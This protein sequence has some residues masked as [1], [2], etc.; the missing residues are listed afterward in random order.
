MTDNQTPVATFKAKAKHLHNILEK[1]HPGIKLAEC[2]EALSKINGYRDWNTASALMQRPQGITDAQ[3]RLL[4][5]STKTIVPM[6][7]EITAPYPGLARYS[8]QNCAK[9]Y[10]DSRQRQVYEQ[11][12]IHSEEGQEDITFTFA[13]QIVLTEDSITVQDGVTELY[14]PPNALTTATKIV[15]AQLM[16][17][18]LEPEI[19][20]IWSEP[21]GYI[22]RIRHHMLCCS[23][24]NPGKTIFNDPQATE[25]LKK[26]MT[27]AFRASNAILDAYKTLHG[28]W[29][30]Q[31]KI[32][33]LQSAIW[34]EL[35]GGPKYMA[36]TTEF[37]KVTI[38]GIT[39]TGIM[40]DG[41]YI[42]AGMHGQQ[43]GVC[44]IVEHNYEKE[45]KIEDII[46]E[47]AK[48]NKHLLVLPTSTKPDGYYI[49]KYGDMH[50][51]SI[52]LTTLT[53]EQVRQLAKEFGIPFMDETMPKKDRFYSSPAFEGLKKWVRE[54]P[55]YAKKLSKE[56]NPY[57]PE[58]YERAT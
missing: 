25:Y 44:S 36:K 56:D 24:A 11:T 30:N 28:D 10:T 35:I 51:L 27:S 3:A 43:L 13:Y 2:L 40:A 50:Q 34:K 48:T 19:V 21:A 45:K 4:E 49:A 17:E 47:E 33:R 31:A 18:T 29:K 57:L 46:E 6:L 53:K 16:G 1:Q 39:F 22:L 58:W 8:D 15:S 32:R 38:G 54:N 42:K 5:F 20:R 7:G 37:H 23:L 9:N 41:P 26:R 55:A 52:P 12:V 14:F